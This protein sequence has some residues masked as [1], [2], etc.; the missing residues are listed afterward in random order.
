MRDLKYIVLTNEKMNIKRAVVFN[1]FFNHYIIAKAIESESNL[2]K[3]TSAGFCVVQTSGVLGLLNI[4]VYG[5]SESLNLESDID[6]CGV[7]KNTLD[8]SDIF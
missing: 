2:W 5:K 3:C 8:R 1:S 6:D 7:I 4:T